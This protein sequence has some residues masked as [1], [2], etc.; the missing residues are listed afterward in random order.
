[1]IKGIIFD[2]DGTLA[3]TIVDLQS[4]MNRMLSFIGYSE[5]TITEIK[6]ALN[7]GA[8]EFVRRSLP[9]EVQH[10]DFI[11]RSALREYEKQY[12]KCYLEKTEAYTN[13]EVMLMNLKQKGI[14]LAVLSNKHDKFV[15]DIVTEL[16]DRKTFV[17]IQGHDKLPLKPNPS[18]AL[19]IAKKMGIKPSQCL[20]VGDSDV[21]IQTAKNASMR[22]VG[23]S[24]GYR[25]HDALENAGATFVVKEANEICE[26]VDHLK[27]ENAKIRRSRAKD[28]IVHT[29]ENCPY[30]NRKL[31]GTTEHSIIKQ[32]M[33]SET[34]NTKTMSVSGEHNAKKQKKN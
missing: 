9:K 30:Y 2:L 34:S 13:I 25:G 16:F 33:T 8:T 21:D 15:K 6:S 1:M 14:K 7:N 27:T 24:W 10:V 28:T 19:A 22:S 3:D 5:R 17:E 20:F 29:T 31:L 18:A 26:I 11:L 4:A 12:S 23:V 32:S